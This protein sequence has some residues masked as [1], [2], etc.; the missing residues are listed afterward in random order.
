MGGATYMSSKF[1]E[2]KIGFATKS[3]QLVNVAASILIAIIVYFAFAYI[4][5]MPELDYVTGMIKK[6][7]KK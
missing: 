1:I 4:L 6:R 5:R 2:S 3:V 7:I